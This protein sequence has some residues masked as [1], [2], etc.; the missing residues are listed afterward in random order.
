MS[1]VITFLVFGSWN[2][3]QVTLVRRLMAVLRRRCLLCSVF[4]P[5][6]D[7]WQ[8]HTRLR[9]SQLDMCFG[10]SKHVDRWGCS[11]PLNLFV[12]VPIMCCQSL[13]FSVDDIV[14]VQTI[15]VSL[16]GIFGSLCWN[17]WVAFWCLQGYGVLL[18]HFIPPPLFT[19]STVTIC[20]FMW[21]L[22][23]NGC[24]CNL[25]SCCHHISNCTDDCIGEWHTV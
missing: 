17:T 1:V 21:T 6:G 4:A 25:H 2:Y 10:R 24:T 23:W 13:P 8:R 14:F 9:S 19:Y 3:D 5:L 18:N 16:W 20:D 22:G 11:S 7:W 12:D 15:C